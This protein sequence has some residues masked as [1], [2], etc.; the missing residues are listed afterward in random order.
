MDSKNEQ[1][2]YKTLGVSSNA[3]EE[4]IKAA[5]REKALKVHPD[6]AG[7]IFQQHPEKYTNLVELEQHLVVEFQKLN[8]AYEILLERLKNSQEIN[9]RASFTVTRSNRKKITNQKLAQLIDFL[10]TLSSKKIST[11]SLFTYIDPTL[12][13]AAITNIDDLADLAFEAKLNS[14]QFAN[15]I[16]CLTEDYIRILI[17]NF[18]KHFDTLQDYF[19]NNRFPE[20]EKKE[21]LSNTYHAMKIFA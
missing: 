16:A 18:W 20:E 11:N 21:Q 14:E 12:L 19:R 13:K 4:Q 1:S 15:L 2:I 17:E 3:T 5:Y 8:E 7:W 9:S 6:K 10:N